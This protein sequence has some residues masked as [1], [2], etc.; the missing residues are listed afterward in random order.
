M[1][2][3]TR[4]DVSFDLSYVLVNHL[5]GVKFISVRPQSAV[6]API[7]SIHFPH[8]LHFVPGAGFMAPHLQRF[9]GSTVRDDLVLVVLG[10]LGLGIRFFALLT[11]FNVKF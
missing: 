4:V 7:K 5:F 3:R 6:Y 8:T 10:C 11:G 2:A 1:K 9:K